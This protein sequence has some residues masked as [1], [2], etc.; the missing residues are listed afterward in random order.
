[1]PNPR[2][3]NLDVL[4]HGSER[5]DELGEARV[6]LPHAIRR[7]A[8]CVRLARTHLVRVGVRVKDRVRVR[9]GVRSVVSGKG[10]WVWVARTSA[11]A[12]TSSAP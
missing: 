11:S 12:A 5:H 3:S 2:A 4:Q 7:R 9:V 8:L 1:M 6:R 10:K